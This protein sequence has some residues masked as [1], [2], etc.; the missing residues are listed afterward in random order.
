MKSYLMRALPWIQIK[1]ERTICTT[2]IQ[3]KHDRGL[4]ETVVNVHRHRF[5]ELDSCYYHYNMDNAAYCT[6]LR[7]LLQFV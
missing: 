2:M 5:E 1:K 3:G 4:F 6:H 7:W